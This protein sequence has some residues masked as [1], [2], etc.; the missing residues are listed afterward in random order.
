MISILITIFLIFILVRPSQAL[1]HIFLNALVK[2]TKSQTG[3]NC[4]YVTESHIILTCRIPCR[5][6]GNTS[7]SNFMLNQA[8]LHKCVDSEMLHG[9]NSRKV[10][11][12]LGLTK[13][14]KIQLF[15]WLGSKVVLLTTPS[16]S[17][18]TY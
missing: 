1:G 10:F 16:K 18:F 9:P 17:Y 8:M 14:L 11:L 13:I 15:A 7:Y 4:S 6:V 12:L 5:V 2:T 3:I